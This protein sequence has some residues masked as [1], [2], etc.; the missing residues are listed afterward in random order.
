MSK[1]TIFGL[2]FRSIQ[3]TVFRESCYMTIIRQPRRQSVSI[4]CYKCTNGQ[5]VTEKSKKNGIQAEK[6]GIK[7]KINGTDGTKKDDFIC[8]PNCAAAEV[9]CAYDY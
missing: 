3:L 9:K 6:G 4:D 8:Q 2:N 1:R 5:S 7:E